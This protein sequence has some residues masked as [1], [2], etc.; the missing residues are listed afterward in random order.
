M[1]DL[2]AEVPQQFAAS[3]SITTAHIDSFTS[4][5]TFMTPGESSTEELK[6]HHQSLK[7][8]VLDVEMGSFTPLVFGTNGG[9]GN[10]CQRVLKH[11]A[12]KIAQKDT[13]PYNTVIA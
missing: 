12:N 1:P 7:R 4:Q 6:R 10:E 8:R 13:E 5:S 3:K 2:R 11:P 9:M